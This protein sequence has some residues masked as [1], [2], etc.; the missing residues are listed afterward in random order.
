MSNN[1][2]RDKVNKHIIRGRV[3]T[4]LLSAFGFAALF[5]TG[6][7]LFFGPRGRVARLSEWQLFDLTRHEWSDLHVAFAS[8]FVIAAF[9]HLAFNWKPFYTYISSRR[10]RELKWPVELLLAFTIVVVTAWLAIADMQP[11][12]WLLDFRGVGGFRQ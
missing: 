3:L 7:V 4:S 12:S 6:L 10:R 9:A 5:G 1:P 11:I 2:M 8:C